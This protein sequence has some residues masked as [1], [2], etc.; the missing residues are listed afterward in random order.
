MSDMTPD[1]FSVGYPLP[2]S[3]KLAIFSWDSKACRTGSL[4]VITHPP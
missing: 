2:A 1:S 4:T 3:I